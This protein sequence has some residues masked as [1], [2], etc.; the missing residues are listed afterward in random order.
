M[1]GVALVCWG[2]SYGN[3]DTGKS[4]YLVKFQ[5]LMFRL[6]IQQKSILLHPKQCDYSHILGGLQK[7]NIISIK[8]G[9]DVLDTQF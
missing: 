5:V 7:R 3:Y 2:G 4:Q 1:F 8:C 9:E 6:C